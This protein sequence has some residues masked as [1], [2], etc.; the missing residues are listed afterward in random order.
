MRYGKFFIFHFLFFIFH[1]KVRKLSKGNQDRPKFFEGVVMNKF[2]CVLVVGTVMFLNAGCHGHIAGSHAESLRPLFILAPGSPFPLGERPFSIALGDWNNDGKLDLVAGNEANKLTVL[3]GDG[4]GSFRPAPGPP[5]PAIAH[6]ITVGDVNNDHNLD[7]AITEH[8]SFGVV[9]LLGKGDGQFAA[10]S[11]S[12]FAA[13]PGVRPHNHGLSIG[14]VNSDGNL[15]LTTSNYEDNS[16]S[17]LI[18]DGKGNFAPAAGSPFSVGRGPYNQTLIDLNRDGKLDVVTP[19]VR[20]NNVTVLLGNGK[21]GFIAA[22]GPPSPVGYRPYYTALGDLNGDGKPDLITTHDDINK[23]AVSLGDG[24][25]AFAAA[26]HSPLDLGSRGY[27]VIITDV[28]RDAKMDVVVGN[29]G[30]NQVSVFLGD[31]QGNIMAAP[32][33]PYA[34]GMGSPTFALGD[35]NGDGKI[36]IVT[37]N[38][39]GS[40]GRIFLGT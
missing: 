19:N 36:D 21:G 26:P 14:D 3:L 18:G 17:V 23:M 34:S 33:S 1:C 32:G 35:V 10:A 38:S 37:A 13:L 24:R 40:E 29:V 28:N 31:G 27:K 25:G 8:D 2:V 11:G 39:E 9:V 22:A 4:R 15:D 30:V 6:L 20:D 16:V 7:L 5:L 12:P